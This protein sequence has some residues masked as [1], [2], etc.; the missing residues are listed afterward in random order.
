[1]PPLS[2]QNRRTGPN[3]MPLGLKPRNLHI[4]ERVSEIGDAMKRYI[5]AGIAVPESW[6]QE[7]N[8]LLEQLKFMKP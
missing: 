3:K 7:H 1:M 6:V 2:K 5:N 8:E 4:E